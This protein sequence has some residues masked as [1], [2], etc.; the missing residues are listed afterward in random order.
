MWKL[1]NFH[2][3]FK[4][5]SVEFV[6]CGTFRLVLTY[7]IISTRLAFC[8]TK[9][10]NATYFNLFLLL[11]SLFSTGVAL[12][13]LPPTTLSTCDLGMLIPI[14]LF[15]SSATLWLLLIG[16]SLQCISS[17]GVRDGWLRCDCSLLLLRSLFSRSNSGFLSSF[18]DSAI[19][20]LVCDDG[21]ERKRMC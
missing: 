1:L 7:R 2:H 19:L 4:N 15:I 14:C 9:A 8:A 3:N 13:T 16:C 18:A 12:A 21:E 17:C 5:S 11:L 20:W 10:I 6:N